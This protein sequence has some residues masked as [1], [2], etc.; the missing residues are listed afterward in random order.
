MPERADFSARWILQRS[1]KAAVAGALTVMGLHHAVR[2][3]RRRQ[4]GGSRVLILSYHR[5][6]PD[7]R[8]AARES[9]PS[10]LVS[11]ETLR[12]ALEHVG[13]YH[14]LVSLSDARR[15]LAEPAQRG[16][17]DVVAV[18][19]DDGYGDVAEHAL[20]V[21]A[22]LRVPATVF[23]PTGYIG[24]AR[25][26]PH[27]RLHASLTELQR[28]GVPFERAGLPGGIQALL[29]A[30][31]ESGPARCLRSIFVPDDETWFLLYEAPTVEQLARRS[32]AVLMDLRG[33]SRLNAG[34][35]FELQQLYAAGR[36]A[37]CVFVTDETSD[38][39]LAARSLGLRESEAEPWV[40]VRHL[41]AQA[42]HTLW[43]RLMSAARR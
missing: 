14:E 7:F 20:P 27:D 43:Q 38:R 23:V 33:F 29:S 12:R 17:R 25:R 11:T 30:A 4:A 3:V 13:R 22:D 2:L 42:L 31:A 35:V 15:I 34:C 24:T 5:V 19:L 16:A 9:L 40:A 28:R 18:T 10:L 1:A 37:N 26:L 6:T 39:G 32:D 41:D 21:L 36:L 8:A